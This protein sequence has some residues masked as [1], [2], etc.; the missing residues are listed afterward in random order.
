MA[1]K[2]DLKHALVLLKKFTGWSYEKMG[3]R[4][5]IAMNEDGVAAS[6][7]FRISRGVMRPHNT[8]KMWVC[9]ATEK[10]VNNLVENGGLTMSGGAAIKTLLPKKEKE[11]DK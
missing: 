10:L 9:D 5:C 7:L 4:M 2:N 6:T 3:R 8:T 1:K 11:E